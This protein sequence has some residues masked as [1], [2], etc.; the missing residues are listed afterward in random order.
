MYQI[1]YYDLD[2]RRDNIEQF[3]DDQW[4][5]ARTRFNMLQS[6]QRIASE[7]IMDLEFRGEMP[8]SAK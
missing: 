1:I 4:Q 2:E 7:R 5:E 8:E 3:A 6:L